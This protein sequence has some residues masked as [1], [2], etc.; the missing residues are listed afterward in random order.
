MPL[1]DRETIDGEAIEAIE[2]EEL[3]GPRRRPRIEILGYAPG[4]LT[5]RESCG[6]ILLFRHPHI[7][8]RRDSP[9]ARRNAPL[10]LSD[11]TGAVNFRVVR[12]LR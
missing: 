6:A 9:L 5:G 2:S 7:P 10:P 1:C 3:D 11:G 8:T 12:S 4:P